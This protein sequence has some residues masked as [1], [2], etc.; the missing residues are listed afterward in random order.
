MKRYLPYILC[1]VL[2]AGIGIGCFALGVH[3]Q[4]TS[5][6]QN[7]ASGSAPSTIGMLVGLLGFN[8]YVALVTGILAEIINIGLSIMGW[9]VALSG[10]FLNIAMNMTLNIKAFVD[11]TAA[12]YTTWTA[13]RDISSMFI[14]FFLLWAAI[15]MIIGIQDPKFGQLIKNIVVAGVLVNFSFFAAGLGIDAS[16]IVSMQLYNAIAPTNS[17]NA[18]N[19]KFQNPTVVSS[20]LNA[21]GL[22]DIF[23]QSLQITNIY[24]TLGPTT[25]KANSGD[26]GAAANVMSAPLKIILMGVTGIIIEFTAACSFTLAA[27]AFIFRFVLLLVLLAFSP[28]WFVSVIIP[29][30]EIKKYAKKWTGTYFNML[31]FMPVYLLLMYLA[32]NVLTTSTF[33]KAGYANNLITNPSAPWYSNFLILGVNAFIVIFLLNLP[34]VAAIEMGGV[35]TGWISK[36][37]WTSGLNANAIWKKFGGATYTGT[38]GRATSKIAQSEGFKDFAARHSTI[39]GTLLKGTRGLASGYDE[40]LQKQIDTR[41]KFAESLGADQRQVNTAQTALRALQGQLASAK[42]AYNPNGPNAAAQQAYINTLDTQVGRAKGN[43]ASIENAR[44]RAYA[45]SVNTRSVD[46]LLTKVARKNKVASAKIQIPI[47]EKEV[48][49]RKES[50]KETQQDIKQL[51]NAIRGNQAGAQGAAG[52]PTQAQAIELGRLQT[53][54]VTKTTDLSRDEAALDRLKLTK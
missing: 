34:L 47:V 51:T 27:A 53:E 11:G 44:K 9:L 24:G 29:S 32:L 39:G 8:N 30:D 36:N 25:A 4:T 33:F 15:Q 52:T 38:V 40:K 41:T 37:K 50:L 1:F 31:L 21:G 18:A 23:M 3:A 17:I 6:V 45:T 20:L 26:L 13:I 49:R 5:G 12:I 19:L 28:I 14:I 10:V 7:T 54:E 43:V 48:T 16:N 22:S 2:I 35:A 46:T 42:A